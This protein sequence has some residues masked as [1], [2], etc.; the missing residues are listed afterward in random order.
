MKQ[1]LA[2]IIAKNG[3]DLAKALTTAKAEPETKRAIE[4]NISKAQTK[5]AAALE[6]DAQGGK[7]K[8]S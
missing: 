3:P 8:R 5:M 4:D 2:S 1:T 7:G 6:L